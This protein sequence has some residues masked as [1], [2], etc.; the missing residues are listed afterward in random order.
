MNPEE[1]P[2]KQIRTFQGDVA[3]VLQRE[4]G[5]L[6]SIQRAEHL[7]KNPLHDTSSENYKNKSESFFLLVGSLSENYKNKSESFFLL[8]GSLLLFTLGM[9]GV[10]YAYNAFIK[11][12]A[13]PVTTAS[14]NRFIPVDAEINLNLTATSREALLGIL[15]S[16]VMG[17]APKELRHFIFTKEGASEPSYL[18]PIS[19]FLEGLE[20][21]APSNLV[22]AFDPPFMFGALEESAFLI[23]K[24]SSF[25][26]A[27]AGMLA[28]EKTL[29]QDIGPLF[30]TSELLRNLPIDSVFT[31]IVDKNK[32]VR[33]LMSGDQIVLLYS[34]F[35]NNRLIITDNIETLRILIDRLIQEKLSR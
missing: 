20:V 29:G 28:W 24:L 13:T 9:V 14:A 5:S 3:E 19:E 33:I 6:V 25:E 4:R 2:L 1:T 21:R 12:G 30:A 8:V 17:G 16:A 10:W 23:I 15:S 31:D 32:D 35:D 34:F 22:R 27:F 11:G 7:K 18:F 26:N